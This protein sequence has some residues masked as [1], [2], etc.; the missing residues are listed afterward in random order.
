MVKYVVYGKKYHVYMVKY[1]VNITDSQTYERFS[2]PTSNRNS[3]QNGPL[4]TSGTLN[5][6]ART[7]PP[8]A[9]TTP[10]CADTNASSTK[11]KTELHRNS[12]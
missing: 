5:A 7:E 1:M 8:L 10:T 12:T 6:T 2:M 4:A 3:M 9:V 11:Y